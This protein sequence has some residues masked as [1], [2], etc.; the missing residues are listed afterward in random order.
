MHLLDYFHRQPKK[1]HIDSISFHNQFS[2]FFFYHSSND[3]INGYFL[4]SRNHSIIAFRLLYYETAPQF[5]WFHHLHVFLTVQLANCVHTS[6]ISVCPIF[7]MIKFILCI[8]YRIK[9]IFDFCSSFFGYILHGNLRT[10]LLV[11]VNGVFSSIIS[12][13]GLCK[14][15]A[16]ILIFV[17]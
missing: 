16:D 9:N 12:S 4:K 11:T 5:F 2:N 15:V 8:F 1:L 7:P 13:T 17:C 14:Y 6:S 3:F 10:C